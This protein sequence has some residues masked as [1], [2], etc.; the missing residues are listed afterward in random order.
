MP[1]SCASSMALGVRRCSCSK[2]SCSRANWY[3]RCRASRGARTM[4][5]I[6]PGHAP[7]GELGGNGFRQRE[8]PLEQTVTQLPIPGLGIFVQSL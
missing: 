3:S 4:L 5:Q 2:R 1:I 7:T 6:L 8:Q